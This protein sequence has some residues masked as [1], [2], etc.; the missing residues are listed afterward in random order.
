MSSSDIHNR[1]TE[2][3][4][5]ARDPSTQMRSGNGLESIRFEPISLP[6][7]DFSEIRIDSIFL[8]KPIACPIMIAS[9]SGGTKESETLNE[10]LAV[11]AQAMQIPLALGSMR[12]AIEQRELKKAFQLRHIA[13]TIPILANIGG[14][15]LI[16][17]GGIQRALDCA[18][19][20][21]ADA[22]IVHLNPLQE[23]LQP[24]GD[25]NW[26]GVGN[27]IKTLVE[28]SAVPIIVKEVGHGLGTTSVKQLI[29]LG[30]AWIDLAGTG[31]TSWAMIEALRAG[32]PQRAEIGTVFA[33]FGIS[34]VETLNAINQ[35]PEQYASCR[36]IASGGI[37]SGLDVARA[38]R[39]GATLCSAAKPFLDAAD[40]GPEAI[41]S[42]IAT[43]CEQLK[44]T[45]FVTG[46]LDIECLKHA[47][48][49]DAR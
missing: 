4:T 47:R 46:S 45:C 32:A 5:L 37:R 13:P 9:M 1:K 25:R 26:R 33:D 22:L 20:A 35:E 18:E 14:A 27:A 23:A 42:V 21:A 43:W 24:N 44:V 11:A 12:I 31:G 19:I 39:A 7:I 15:Q 34:A 2:H 48:L 16:E 8:G 49:L 28:E 40:K 17:A 38:L 29:D 36:F 6:E 41:E 3:L 30:V 10:R